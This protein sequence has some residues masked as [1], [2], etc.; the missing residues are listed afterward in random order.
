MT[1]IVGE[2]WQIVGKVFATTLLNCTNIGYVIMAIL[3]KV[4]GTLHLG[5]RKE[6]LSSSGQYKPTKITR[7][8]NNTNNSKQKQKQETITSTNNNKSYSPL[9]S[10]LNSRLR[11]KEAVRSVLCIVL[12]SSADC[13]M[14][15]PCVAYSILAVGPGL[16]AM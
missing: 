16:M 13:A 5:K 8:H 6:F 10:Y 12:T 9:G 15:K 7:S 3:A 4:K 11:N 1:F 14:K 2:N